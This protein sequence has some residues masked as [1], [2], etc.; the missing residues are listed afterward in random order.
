MKLLV[1]NPN[2]S[3]GITAA[4]VAAAQAAA[5]PGTI[6]PGATGT[7]G[8]AYIATRGENIIGAHA[9]LTA[10]AEATSRDDFD[11]V[12]VAA[13]SDPGLEAIREL[14]SLSRRRDGAGRHGSGGHDRTLR[15]RDRRSRLSLA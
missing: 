10:F 7:F 11:G 3:D 4:A 15:D 9:A 2:I 1:I 5:Q 14:V 6:N 8:V 13:F 12:I